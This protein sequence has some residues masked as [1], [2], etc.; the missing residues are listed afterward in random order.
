MVNKSS[1]VKTRTAVFTPFLRRSF[2]K[3]VPA[4]LKLRLNGTALLIG[5]Q[6]CQDFAVGLGKQAAELAKLNEAM[7]V[8]ISVLRSALRIR[9]PL[10]ADLLIEEAED[11][12]WIKQALR[13]EQEKAKVR[14]AAASARMQERIL[15]GKGF[16]K[17]K[18]AVT[19]AT[20]TTAKTAVEPTRTPAHVI[21]KKTKKSN[22]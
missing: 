18:V 7:T 19:T 9:Y 13:D 16:A 4:G 15:N 12:A 17:K 10:L 1:V 14:S 21:T 5:D 8:D 6:M 3:R 11:S 20:T 2:H 22:K